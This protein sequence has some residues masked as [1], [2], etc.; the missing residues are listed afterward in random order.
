MNKYEDIACVRSRERDG[1]ARS[2]CAFKLF[3]FLVERQVRILISAAMF[4]TQRVR[5]EYTNF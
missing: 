5:V 1:W 4:G 2:L 3:H